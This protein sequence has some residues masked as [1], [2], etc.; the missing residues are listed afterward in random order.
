MSLEE[1][2]TERAVSYPQFRFWSIILQ[3][4]LEVMMYVRALR[5]AN[6]LI[7]IGAL[8]KIVPLFFT[9][10]HTHYA[11]WIPVHLRDMIIL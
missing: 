6:F 2:C 1:W 10:G 4:E 5:K 7:Y 9:L 8:T 11:R 3:L